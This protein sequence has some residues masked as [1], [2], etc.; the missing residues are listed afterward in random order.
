[1]S[2]ARKS[3]QQYQTNF[4]PG[5][6]EAIAELL[7]QGVPP[8]HLKKELER[9]ELKR[10]NL[11]WADTESL[12]LGPPLQGPILIFAGDLEEYERCVAEQDLDPY[13]CTFADIPETLC[14]RPCRILK[15]E[16]WMAHP[17]HQEHTEM[18][19]LF[20]EAMDEAGIEE[21]WL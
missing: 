17:I 10:R 11:L 9:L 12:P 19:G 4:S 13:D 3:E 8:Q 1:M 21:E 18:V 5:S 2:D 14:L 7:H 16:N 20:E 15:C 6:E